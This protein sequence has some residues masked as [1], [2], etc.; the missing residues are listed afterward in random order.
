MGYNST[1]TQTRAGLGLPQCAQENPDLIPS[2]PSKPAFRISKAIGLAA[3]VLV[4][5]GFYCG[6]K[7]DP[8]T[9][10]VATLNDI[11]LLI[12]DPALRTQGVYLAWSYPSDAKATY[13]E[14]Y[15]SLTKDSLRHS[16]MVQ[17]ARDSQHA[18]LSLSDTTRPFTQYFAVRAVYVEPTGQKVVSGSMAIDSISVTPSLKILQPASGSFMPGRN[19]DM[20]VQTSSDPGV[21][22]RYAYY[23]ETGPGWGLKQEGWLPFGEDPTPIFGNSVQRGSLTLDPYGETDTV[24]A[25]YCVVGTES[26]EE[27][28]TGQTQSLGCSRFFRVGR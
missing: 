12:K 10:P 1:K 26:F 7:S 17:S 13:F 27:R 18:V 25:L 9:L 20:E 2:H 15:Q 14:I 23:E 22:I 11:H 21:V 28:T 8:P 16:V 6:E 5:Q 24:S 4:C 3:A 19:L